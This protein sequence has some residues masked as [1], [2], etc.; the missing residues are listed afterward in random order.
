MSEGA[1]PASAAVA[2]AAPAEDSDATASDLSQRAA[3]NK[4]GSPESTATGE[5]GRAHRTA[6]GTWTD[7][8]RGSGTG[9][10]RPAEPAGLASLADAAARLLGTPGVATPSPQVPP[11]GG[12]QA[13]PPTAPGQPAAAASAAL[14]HVLS[15]HSTA[16]FLDASGSP[17]VVGPSA[18]H[19]DPI[20]PPHGSR[21]KTGSCHHDD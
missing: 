19:I 8:A 4:Q 21:G 13:T 20:G 14:Q 1:T 12:A 6:A 11:P 15:G 16:S 9:R 10:G 5:A 17:R 2:A 18:P 3:H 7:Q